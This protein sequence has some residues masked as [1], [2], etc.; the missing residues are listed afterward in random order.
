[1]SGKPSPI[2]PSVLAWAIAE[3]GRPPVEI[4]EALKIDDAVL[5]EWAEG[6]SQPAVAQVT[7][8][9]KTLKRPRAMFFM[10][11]PLISA[12]LPPVSG[13]R[14]AMTGR[15]ARPHDARSGRPGRPGRCR[16]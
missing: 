13:T 1:M 8:L 2:T 10:P 9:G 14:P 7:D 3:D 6:E 16:P 4:A 15:S 12:S 11:Q 5:D